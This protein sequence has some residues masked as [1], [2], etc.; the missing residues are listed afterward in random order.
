MKIIFEW[1]L[2][3]LAAFLL[4]QTLFFKF[5]ASDESVYIFTRIGLEPYGR[6]GSGVLELIAGVMLLSNKYRVYGA[7]LGMLVISGAL[8][9]H[10]TSLGIEVR[11]DDG[12]L[13]YYAVTVFISCALLLFIRKKEIPLLGSKI[14]KS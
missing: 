8:F 4:L 13:F 12:R 2:S 14:Q 6:I 3:I 7:L 5:S 1:L 11:G 9:F 10:L